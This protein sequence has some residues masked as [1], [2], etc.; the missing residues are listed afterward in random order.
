MS[1]TTSTAF[2]IQGVGSGYGQFCFLSTNTWGIANASSLALIASGSTTQALTS[3]VTGA[4]ISEDIFLGV[5]NPAASGDSAFAFMINNGVFSTFPLPSGA[6][7]TT[8]ALTTYTVP[9]A[10]DNADLWVMAGD[11]EQTDVSFLNLNVICGLASGTS[12]FNSTTY[13]DIGSTPAFAIID[14]I[15]YINNYGSNIFNTVNLVNQSA[16]YINGL[17]TFNSTPLTLGTLNGNI[18]FLG[19]SNDIHITSTSSTMLFTVPS[20]ALPANIDAVLNYNGTLFVV[21]WVNSQAMSIL[22]AYSPNT[23]W[24]ATY[25]PV[26]P[27]DFNPNNVVVPYAAFDSVAGVLYGDLAGTAVFANLSPMEF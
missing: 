4:F 21:D 16:N 11:G 6:T 7:Y 3:P 10:S 22:L 17:Y 1:T 14:N 5:S 20:S 13:D 15:A 25:S 23:G 2:N 18:F 24:S 26:F 12:Y 9:S 8:T 27:L 19:G